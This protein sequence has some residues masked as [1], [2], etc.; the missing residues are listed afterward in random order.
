[1]SRTSTTRWRQVTRHI[2]A[3]GLAN[4]T[5]CHLCQGTLGPIDYR[6]QSQADNDART[7]GEYWL[8]KAPRPLALSVDHLLPH[9]AGGD[10]TIDNAAPTHRICN[11]LAGAKGT[12]RAS[13]NSTATRRPRKTLGTW[14]PLNG[15]GAA[16]PGF[17]TPGKRTTTHVFIAGSHA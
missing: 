2:R 3:E 11:E 12:P 4:N 6:T 10:D 7:S 14:Q 17:D 16:L 5:P 15:Q 1:M 13:R 8:I 9:A